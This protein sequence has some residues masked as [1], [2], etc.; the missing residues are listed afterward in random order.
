MFLVFLALSL[1]LR[2]GL[3]MGDVKLAGMLGFLLG[4]KVLPAIAVGAIA[5]VVVA[6]MLLTRTS[7][8]RSTMA[9]GPCLALGGAVVIL[10]SQPP[11]LI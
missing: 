1:V 9:Y 8:R 7:G 10:L 3:G 5:G 6:A 11:A 2:G 4:W